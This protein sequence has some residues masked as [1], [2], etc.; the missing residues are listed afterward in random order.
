MDDL[1]ETYVTTTAAA[2]MLSMHPDSMIYLLR[3]GTL[4]AVKIAYRWL[5][6]RSAVEELADTYV[7]RR[8]RPRVKRK[9]TK[10]SAKWLNK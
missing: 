5:I 4:P 3:R 10:R 7:P 1:N 6:L 8:G 2:A 9:Y